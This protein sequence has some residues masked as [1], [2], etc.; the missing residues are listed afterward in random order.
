MALAAGVWPCILLA[1]D[2]PVL[3]IELVLLAGLV[4]DA[5]VCYP[6]PHDS[7]I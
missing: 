4:R 5:I 2:V 7:T 3:V 1:E 6:T